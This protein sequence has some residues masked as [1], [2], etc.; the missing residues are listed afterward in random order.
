MSIALFR[1]V[2]IKYRKQEKSET[3]FRFG[4]KYKHLFPNQPQFNI[5]FMIPQFYHQHENGV[6]YRKRPLKNKKK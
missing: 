6:F 2:P 3:L 4:R 5:S 1:Y